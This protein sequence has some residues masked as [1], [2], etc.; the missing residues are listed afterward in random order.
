MNNSIRNPFYLLVKLVFL[1][2]FFTSCSQS[3]QKEDPL[4]H[5]KLAS[6]AIQIT[7]ILAPNQEIKMLADGM[8]FLEGPVWDDR[9]SQ[10]I[11]SEVMANK[12]HAW[13]EEKG[14]TTYLEPS[15]YAG[16]N[17][18]TKE[19][20]LISCQGGA[21]QIALIKA[22]KSMEI[23]ASKF[24]GKKFNSPNDVVQKSDG[25]IWFTDPDYGLLAAYG[26]KASEFRELEAYHIFRYD[27]HTK[28]THSVYANLSKPNGLVFSQDESKLYVGN[29]A[30]GDRKL[31][32]FEVLKD[33]S[34]SAPKTLASISS[35]TWGIDGLKMDE[36]GNLYAA[37]GD[38]INIFT[39]S[40]QLIGKIETDF[41][42]TNLCFGGKEGKTLFMTGH[43]ALYSV[44]L[45]VKGK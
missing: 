15:Y 45:S 35:K 44:K 41:E 19:G 2:V 9:N 31:L 12:L 40:G 24:E 3:K 39:P 7:D 27:P 16:G 21:R 20:E 17:F 11:F 5:T 23:L 14:L 13:S 8:Q 38:G 1:I 28:R 25:S 36:N 10:L 33:N 29:S 22:D 6:Q 43:E 34:L 37:C 4:N 18:L 30:E 42:V 32:A 26:E